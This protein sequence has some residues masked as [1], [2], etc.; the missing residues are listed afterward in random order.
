MKLG[1][2]FRYQEISQPLCSLEMTQPLYPRKEECGALY[3]YMRSSRKR[4]AKGGS[5]ERAPNHL[6]GIKLTGH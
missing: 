3:P 6:F 1:L 4:S 5:T 2:V